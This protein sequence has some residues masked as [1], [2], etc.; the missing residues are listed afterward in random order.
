MIKIDPEFKSLIP[1]LTQE[2]YNQLE[3]N[4]IKETNPDSIVLLTWNG[5]LIDGHN[6]YEI[7]QKHNI[8]FKA[9]EKN[10][11]ADR[12]DVKVWIIQNQ[13]GRRNI[14]NYVRSK[15]ALELEGLFQ[16]KA[17]EQHALKHTEQ[18]KE[19]AKE[20]KSAPLLEIETVKPIETT[21]QELAKIA[22]VSHDTI[23][24][25]KKIEEKAKPEIKKRL[26]TGEASI[27]EVYKEIKQ[28]EKKEK[29]KSIQ[30]EIE[31][32]AQ[33]EPE[34]PKLYTKDWIDVINE[35]QEYDLLL[36]DPPYSTDIEDI[37]KFANEWLPLAL[38]KIKSTGR[39]YVF[40]GAYP[41]EIQSY[42][43]AFYSIKDCK[44]SLENI[45][46]WTYRNT[47]GPAPKDNY[48]I[49]WQ[50]VLYFKGKDAPQL[51]CPLMN[52]Q[53]T[54][55]DINAPD[56]RFGNRYHTWQK[57]NEI[58]ERFI[59]HSTKKGDIVFDPFS[60]TGTFILAA[61]K[62]NRVGI[63]CEINKDMASISAQR[64]CDVIPS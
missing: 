28:E 2:E 32:Q 25:V 51:T 20:Q 43:N 18:Y 7:C 22:K 19:D 53:F 42:L 29:L 4:I 34:K 30:E 38:S 9:V 59:R 41:K 40:I 17:K 14:N 13:F 1:P 50:A 64:G 26:E 36:T 49:N 37:T 33:A 5:T 60:G 23:T 48:K 16:K 8:Q 27:N 46:V 31:K 6:R 15:L 58:A 39:A 45:L 21:R 54:V 52:E 44:L 35:I 61:N 47:I 62:L 56:G 3:Q 55:Q 11:F 10:G 63:G 57:P 24:K 12:D